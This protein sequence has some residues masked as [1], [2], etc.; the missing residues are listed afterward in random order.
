MLL[1]GTAFVILVVDAFNVLY[2]FPVLEEHMAQG[3]L[4]QARTGLL[5]LLVEVR[6]AWKK[7]I[8]FHVFFDGKKNKGDPTEEENVSGLH[9][10]YSQDLSADHLI[11]K[12]IKRF[13]T[14]AD[15]RV[16]TSDKDILGHA[17]KWKCGVQT[18]EEF[19]KWVDQVLNPE[20]P[21]VEKSPDAMPS[22]K[23]VDYWMTVFTR[24]KKS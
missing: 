13:V 24:R 18:S 5:E 17:K 8:E 2:K 21:P 7:P 11:K 19:A 4:V 1:I 22:S 15:L 9:I 6:N 10:Y 20:I 12:W 14:P 16:V 3:R 23:D